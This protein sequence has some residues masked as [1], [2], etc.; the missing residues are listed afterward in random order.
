M[1]LSWTQT[2]P[3]SCA[4]E[5][6]YGKGARFATYS[7]FPQGIIV[8]PISG[9]RILNE[10]ADRRLR[11]EAIIKSG[12]PCIGIVDA[13]GA[14]LDHESLMN[15]LKS[16]KVREFK[17]LLALAEAYDIPIESFQKTIAEYNKMIQMKHTPGGVGIDEHARVLNLHGNPIPRLFA[18]GEVCGGIHGASRLGSCALP[19]CLIFGR[20]AGKEAASLPVR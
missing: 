8:D 20:I 6:G 12:H 15:C 17:H 10:W 13:K 16:G 19:E 9:F 5:A 2:G 4:D 7:V 18:A 3:W 1:H 14:Q 11:S